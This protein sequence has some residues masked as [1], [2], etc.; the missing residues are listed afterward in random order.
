MSQKCIKNEYDG[1]FQLA[2]WGKTENETPSDILL[3]VDLPYIVYRQCI[4]EVPQ[5]FRRYITTDKFCAGF[6]NGK[7]QQIYN[8]YL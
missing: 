5:A 3:Y 6:S 8:F 1:M 2:G 4:N 7:V